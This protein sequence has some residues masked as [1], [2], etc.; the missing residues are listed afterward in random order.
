MDEAVASA[1]ED[2]FPDRVVEEVGPAG[3][4]WNENNR[5]TRIEFADNAP[6]Y[7]KIASD[8]DSSRLARERA[9]I[10]YVDTR[11]EGAVPAICESG[12]E[13]A[14]PYLAT[15][16]LPGDSVADAWENWTIPE[17]ATV[18]RLVG[19]TVAGLH[20][21]SF[22]SHGRIVDGDAD[23]LELRPEP[24]PDMLLG[25]IEY[26]RELAVSDRFDHHFDNVAAAVEANRDR[27]ETAPAVLVHGDVTRGNCFR[28]ENEIGLIDWEDAHAAD[29]VRELR[30][31]QHQLLE[32]G[33]AEAD[34]ETI[35]ALEEGY[36]DR[37]GGLPE[38]YA[39]RRPIYG[40]LSFLDTSGF[41]D[42][43]APDADEP[44]EELARW[45]EEE[46]DRRLA[47]I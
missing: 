37:A 11:G 19:R 20:E 44:T 42:N 39:D 12:L 31:T 35:D 4:S 41:F 25:S 33:R 6:V 1:L 18:A 14:F 34:D 8:G 43:W 40:A 9:V 7:L 32:P 24:W 28:R 45:V 27:L 30:R 38:G 29:P 5:T 36:R 3:P 22:E 26:I 15:E 10:G 21:T 46:M 23:G 13:A 2:A 47:A 17:R 16:P